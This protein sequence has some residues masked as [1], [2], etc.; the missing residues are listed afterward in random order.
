MPV[1]TV[2]EIAASVAVI[3]IAPRS[4]A[5]ALRAVRL[6]P[7]PAF[8]W[9]TFP[10]PSTKLML[11]AEIPEETPKEARAGPAPT[12]KTG[13]WPEPDTVNEVWRVSLPWRRACEVIAGMRERVMTKDEADESELTVTG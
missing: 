6:A 11:G 3:G 13:V 5:R 10:E 7:A 9:T 4:E 12:A 8:A 1:P 2:A